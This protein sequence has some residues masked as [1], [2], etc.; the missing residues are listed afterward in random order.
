MAHSKGS[1]PVAYGGWTGT[2]VLKR[3]D[4]LPFREGIA[5]ALVDIQ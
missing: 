1:R 3:R 2:A 4:V 5:V